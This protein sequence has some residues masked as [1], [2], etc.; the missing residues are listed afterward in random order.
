MKKSKR[1]QKKRKREQERQPRPVLSDED[2]SRERDFDP[3]GGAPAGRQPL[4]GTQQEMRNPGGSSQSPAQNGMR[5]GSG[6]P[7]RTQA[8]FQRGGH[9]SRGPGPQ[10]QQGQGRPQRRPAQQRQSRLPGRQ[11]P[12]QS[13]VTSQENAA[14]QA[15]QQQ[16]GGPQQSPGGGGFQAMSRTGAAQR[17]P[18]G[19]EPSAAKKV[20]PAAV[21][22][23]QTGGP[24]QQLGASP[25]AVGEHTQAFQRVNPSP[26]E[27]EAPSQSRSR[28][29]T[30]QGAASPQGSSVPHEIPP[31]QVGPAAHVSPRPAGSPIN[32]AVKGGQPVAN[33]GFPNQGFV[34]AA[35]PQR[36]TASPSRTQQEA[37]RLAAEA[38]APAVNGANTGR[39][40]GPLAETG[41]PTESFDVTSISGDAQTQAADTAHATAAFSPQA[42]V[43]A[44][45]EV[46]TT[47]R[48]G[49]E[50]PNLKGRGKADKRTKKPLPKS[51]SRKAPKKPS[52][53]TK[54]ILAIALSVIVL[55]GVAVAGFMFL[56]GGSEDSSAD[57]QQSEAGAEQTAS[58][59]T[60]TSVASDG[61]AQDGGELSLNVADDAAAIGPLNA[62]TEYQMLVEGVSPGASLQYTVDGVAVGEPFTDTAPGLTLEPGRRV[63]GL[64]QTLDGEVTTSTGVAVYVLGETPTRSYRAN[65]RSVNVVT[66]GWAEAVRQFDLLK[67]THPDLKLTPSDPY[68]SLTPGFW[69]LYVDGFDSSDTAN[70]YCQEKGLEVPNDCFSKLFDPAEA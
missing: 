32:R 44:S 42:A 53:P 48:P 12:A 29:A 59:G 3:S 41:P 38:A 20:N 11:S 8:Q 56:T 36:G 47:V 2:Y 58:P 61:P 70:A 17:R 45:S 6:R 39:N 33:Q 43:P 25:S 46:V 57:G 51:G 21:R 69:N 15:G 63:I 19:S 16:G 66:E 5:S 23:R 7:Q 64:E 28:S 30:P 49:G 60:E 9:G 34:G 10:A 14:Y 40:Q 27:Q 54:M 68:P 55:A 22:N 37:S 52:E 31:S 62:N 65:L 50:T 18:N 35:I 4:R 1:S 24:S 67:E 13:D 26:A